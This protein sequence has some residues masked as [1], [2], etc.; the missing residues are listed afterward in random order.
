MSSH[1]AVVQYVPCPVRGER[2]N[3]GVIALED[4]IA[5]CQFVDDWTRAE[6]F[7][8]GDVTFLKEFAG[9]V[10]DAVALR[11]KWVID[12]DSITQIHNEWNGS[13]QVTE[14]R[15]SLR[16]VDDLLDYA[17][18]TFLVNADESR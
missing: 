12:R 13:I 15:G 10:A 16:D 3:I 17:A 5:K 8:D 4:N 2:I 9:D 11:S 1:F 6:R 14:L 7:G 18:R